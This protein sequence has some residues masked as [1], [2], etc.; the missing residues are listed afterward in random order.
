MG[1]RWFVMNYGLFLRADALEIQGFLGGSI[2]P[3][4][5]QSLVGGNQFA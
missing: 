3:Q 1:D 5:V 2:L 4:Q